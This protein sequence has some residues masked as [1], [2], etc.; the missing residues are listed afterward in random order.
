MCLTL[1]SILISEVSFKGLLQ[2]WTASQSIHIYT[3]WVFVRKT[4]P[5]I[6]W[7]QRQSPL[8]RAAESFSLHKSHRTNLLLMSAWH[9]WR[10]RAWCFTCALCTLKSKPHCWPSAWPLILK[11]QMICWKKNK[12]ER[13]WSLYNTCLFARDTEEFN[14]LYSCALKWRIKRSIC[15]TS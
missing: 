10:K 15:K 6:W 9:L 12:E 7:N 8:C 14:S 4:F 2:L 3:C 1:T 13:R 5:N 11:R